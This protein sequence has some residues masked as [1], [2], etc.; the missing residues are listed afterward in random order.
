MFYSYVFI[1]IDK[2]KKMWYNII[3]IEV[4][5]VKTQKQEEATLV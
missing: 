4:A 3:E 2:M 5:L 1:A